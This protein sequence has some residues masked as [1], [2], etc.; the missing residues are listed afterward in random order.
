M[1]AGAPGVNYRASQTVG[2]LRSTEFPRDFGGRD[3]PG[4]AAAS[5]DCCQ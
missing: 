3:G 1:L 5:V 4:R 2:F